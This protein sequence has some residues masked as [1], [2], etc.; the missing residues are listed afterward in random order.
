MNTMYPPILRRSGDKVSSHPKA[1]SARRP[2][3][4]ILKTLAS[5]VNVE[6]YNATPQNSAAV[7]LPGN[8]GTA[9]SMALDLYAGPTTSSGL[10]NSFS[11]TTTRSTRGDYLPQLPLLFTLAARRHCWIKPGLAASLDEMPNL[12]VASP[13]SEDHA[14]FPKRPSVRHAMLMIQ[15]LNL[16]KICLHSIAAANL[17][18]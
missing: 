13:M 12:N 1:T 11:K 8:S 7:V 5:Y 6:S 9:V 2:P 3:S 15:E 18:R 16:V 10:P 4:R 17:S 14:R